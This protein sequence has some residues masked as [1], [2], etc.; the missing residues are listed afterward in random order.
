[1]AYPSEVTRVVA[2][3]DRPGEYVWHCHLLHHEDHEMM[4]PFVVG[5]MGSST[6]SAAAGSPSLLC[7]LDGNP[8]V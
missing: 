3:F 6:M 7:D 1:V 4:R 2:K 5:P 8:I